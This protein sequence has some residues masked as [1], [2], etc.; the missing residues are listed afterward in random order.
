MRIYMRHRTFKDELFSQVM[1]FVGKSGTRYNVG[2]YDVKKTKD[3]EFIVRR[4][5]KVIEEAA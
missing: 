1:F 3:G 5:G 4:D 2:Y